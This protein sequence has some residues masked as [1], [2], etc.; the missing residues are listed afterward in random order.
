MVSDIS[1]FNGMV[2]G[3]TFRKYSSLGI[4]S[5]FGRIYYRFRDN[6]TFCSKKSL[7]SHPTLVW[8]PPA[9]E[10]CAKQHNLGL[11]TAE[12]YI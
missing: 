1:L 10:R 7:F 2:I 8:R 4:N 6:D 5:N 3:N 12:N 9:E 11:Y